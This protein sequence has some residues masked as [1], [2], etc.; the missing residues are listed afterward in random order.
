MSDRNKVALEKKRAEL[1][2]KK[3]EMAYRDKKELQ[4]IKHKFLVNLVNGRYWL[5]R[6]NM[7]AEQISSDNILELVDGAK[8]TKELAMAEYASLKVQAIDHMR[9]AH[10]L[11]KDLLSRE[12]S[13]EEIDE[14]VNSYYEGKI[15]RE[16]WNDDDRHNWNDAGFVPYENKSDKT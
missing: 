14:Y 2:E 11:R 9:E 10:F 15:I 5:E 12:L 6:C 8:K 13:A 16:T 1:E 7:L 3:I 4:R